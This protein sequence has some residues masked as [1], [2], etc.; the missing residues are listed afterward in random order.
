[1]EVKSF[2]LS[3]YRFLVVDGREVYHFGA[4]LRGL[5]GKWFGFS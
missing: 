2:N 1:M 3:H 5:G 4:R